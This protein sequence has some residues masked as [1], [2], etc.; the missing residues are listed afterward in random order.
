MTIV[1]QD[2]S[3]TLQVRTK[4]SN[5]PLARDK[6]AGI[7]SE[8]LIINGNLHNGRIIVTNKFF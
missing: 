5:M 1:Y 2:V 6:I 8:L 4:F 3:S 7:R